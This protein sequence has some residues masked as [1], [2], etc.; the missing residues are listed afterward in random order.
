L[1]SKSVDSDRPRASTPLRRGDVVQ[2]RSP[3]EILATLDATAALD[4]LP[5]MP[6]MLAYFGR[7]Y[8]VSARV[9]RACDTISKTGARRMRNVVLLDDLRCDGSGHN[10]CQAGCRIYWNE[11]WLSRAVENVEPSAEEDPGLERLREL[12]AANT[13][14]P[15]GPMQSPELYRCQA[16]D[17]LKAS[18]PLGWWNVRSF[19]REVSSR[20][21]SVWRFTRVMTRMVVDEL[22]RRLH[23]TTSAPFRS[24]SS[25]S[26]AGA[27][28]GLQ[29]GDRVRVRSASDIAET[30]DETGKLR[31]LWFDREMLPYCGRSATIQTKVDRFIDERSGEMVELSTDCYIL[32]GVV[33]K[34]YISDGRWFCCRG[35]Y[36]WW[37]EAWLD[38]EPGSSSSARG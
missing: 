31:G 38:P 22:A 28:T 30:L 19:V 15:T 8:T 3:S 24:S 17:F 7:T 10:G 32:E 23:L 20:N 16:T 6:E 35:I 26:S 21:V 4:G 12:A 1:L 33:C 29:I 18:E 11:A 14:P 13:R 34:G 25:R 36:P 5:F 27:P 9:E 37:R 2:L